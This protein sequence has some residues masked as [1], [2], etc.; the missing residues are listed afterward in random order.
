MK[1][2][3]LIITDLERGRFG[4]ARSL[5]D[6]LHGRPVLEH[7]LRRAERIEGVSKLVI[8]HPPGQDVPG[9]IRGFG[10][11][12]P[13][14]TF[15]DPTGGMHDADRRRLAARKWSLTGWRGGLGSATC[16]DELL[17]AGP[18][19]AAMAEHH[20]DAAVILGGDWC[21]FDPALASRQ[22]AAHVEAPDAMK[23]VF[24][25]A[26]PGLSG[27]VTSRTVLEDFAK[28][29]AGFGNALGYN[30]RKPVIDPISREVC[31]PVPPTLRDTFERFIHDTPRGREVVRRIA[32]NAEDAG[33]EA[34]ADACAAGMFDHDRVLSHAWLE[35]T[36]RREAN[37][38]VTP[39]HHAAIDRPDMPTD[40]AV[41]FVQRF[42]ADC[43]GATLMIGH[44]GEPLRHD[45]FFDVVEAAHA[46]G[47]FGLGV[48]T[49][50]LCDA[51]TL[52]RLAALPLDVI[53]V[54]FNA[55]TSETYH[56][57]MGIDGFSRVAK[58]LQRLFERLREPGRATPAASPIV[59]PGS[60]WIVPRLTKVRQ[61]VRE[62]ESFF[63]RW[64]TIG[65]CAVIDRFDTGRGR[66]EDHSP[67]PMDPPTPLRT[68]LVGRCAYVL[69]D[70]R[71]T[72]DRSD[73]MGE[74]ALGNL[75][76]TGLAEIWHGATEF[77]EA[78]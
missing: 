56:R 20:A 44:L 70:G 42:A 50:L 48:E 46:A 34:L 53:S 65:G 57:V 71:V 52:E 74:D 3:V 61:N 29:D 18:L 66:A 5:L 67:V 4:H 17:P 59:R 28:H 60:P 41:A 38:P 14:H 32:G 68:P 36:P 26:P 49:D 62:I 51:P 27:V 37:G 30:P 54:R 47:V 40:D 78:G 12:K 33:V 45:G 35:L 77:A 6:G 31:L 8:V 58:N 25:Q 2:V 75:R 24:T 69:S 55:D 1:S 73:W 64:V 22:L 72:S 10:L 19:V 13:I 15:A 23:I 7:T 39:Q 9:A 11:D 76:D 16:Y 21:L 63:D 43:P